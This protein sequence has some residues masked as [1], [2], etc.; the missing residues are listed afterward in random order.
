MMQWSS[1]AEKLK[2][3]AC[4][5]NALILFSCFSVKRLRTCRTCLAT[6]SC[7]SL[8]PVYNLAPT[9]PWRAAKSPSGSSPRSA[10]PNSH[11]MVLLTILHLGEIKMIYL[12]D[13]Q[14]IYWKVFVLSLSVELIICLRSVYI[15]ATVQTCLRKEQ[16]AWRFQEHRVIANK[17]NT[18]SLLK[19]HHFNLER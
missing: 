6:S 17:L 10:P 1:Y 9:R 2:L 7:P 11:R 19:T 14:C 16:S 8:K 12:L 13:Q 3:T 4:Y 5:F 15:H 18:I